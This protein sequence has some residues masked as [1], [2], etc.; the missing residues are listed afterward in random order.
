MN[1]VSFK[2]KNLGWLVQAEVKTNCDECF[3]WL[4]RGPAGSQFHGF[5]GTPWAFCSKRCGRDYLARR[6][7]NGLAIPEAPQLYTKGNIE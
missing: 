1:A 3:N 6:Q 7:A 4:H 2:R 5:I